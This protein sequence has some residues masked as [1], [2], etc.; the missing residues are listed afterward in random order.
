[1]STARRIF[2]EVKLPPRMRLCSHCAHIEVEIGSRSTMILCCDKGYQ[3][4]RIGYFRVL[5]HCYLIGIHDSHL[6]AEDLRI[7]NMPPK[8]SSATA[9]AAAAAAAAAAPIT[10]AAVE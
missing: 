5:R 9:R 4:G 6:D 10:V 2:P 3:D 1:M 7:N 8:R